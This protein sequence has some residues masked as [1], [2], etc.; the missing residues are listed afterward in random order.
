MT[1]INMIHTMRIYYRPMFTACQHRSLRLWVLAAFMAALLMAAAS[2]S[3]QHRAMELVCSGNGGPAKWVASEVTK[4][5]SAS[6]TAG[7]DCPQCLPTNV[8]PP[9]VTPFA[10]PAPA[11]FHLATWRA[12]SLYPLLLRHRPPARAPPF[13]H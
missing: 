6:D 7:M 2:P 13:F 8:L 12:E 11:P 1:Y 10:Q 3:V 4:S 5:T 9:E